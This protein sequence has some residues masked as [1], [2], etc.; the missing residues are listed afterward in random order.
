[1]RVVYFHLQSEDHVQHWRDYVQDAL[2]EFAPVR[3]V[4]ERKS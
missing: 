4:V 2:L 1:M 3:A